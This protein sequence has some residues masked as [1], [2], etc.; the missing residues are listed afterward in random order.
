MPTLSPA[1][2]A[3]YDQALAQVS[4]LPVHLVQPRAWAQMALH[5]A[6]VL[7]GTP[8]AAQKLAEAKRYLACDEMNRRLAARVAQLEAAAR[9][10][11]YVGGEP[12]VSN[13]IAG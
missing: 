9:T 4:A 6:S 5:E 1:A 13:P 12:P 8:E 7:L 10:V 3:A 11:V 2:Q